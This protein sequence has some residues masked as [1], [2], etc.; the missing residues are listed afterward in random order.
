MLKIK[1]LRNFFYENKISIALFLVVGALTS[2]IKFSSFSLFWRI[3]GLSY[4][5]SASIAYFLSVAF[6]FI[7]NRRITFKS[8]DAEPISQVT[9]YIALVALN[10]VVTIGIIRFMTETLHASP[11][12]GLLLAITFMTIISYLLSKY[13]VFKLDAKNQRNSHAISILPKSERP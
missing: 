8:Y 2:L 1:Q 6:H 5:I 7:I 11:Y 9:K 4:T 13:W 3:M 12:F 10:Y